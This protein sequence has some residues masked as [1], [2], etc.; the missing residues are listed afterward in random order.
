MR[1]GVGQSTS[2]PRHRWGSRGVAKTPVYDQSGFTLVELLIAFV[3]LPVVMGAISVGLVSVLSLQSSVTGRVTGSA[4]MQTV[5]SV[6]TRDV[7]SA[8]SITASTSSIA[9]D[10][11]TSGERQ[12]LGLQWA[13]GNAAVSYMVVPMNNGPTGPGNNAL[14]T[15]GYSLERVACVFSATPTSTSVVAYDV[16]A[17]QPTALVSC[18]G[19]VPCDASTWLSA[20]DVAVVRLPLYV[21]FGTTPSYWL[22]A[23]P[24]SAALVDLGKTASIVRAPVSLFGLPNQGCNTLTVDNGGSLTINVN[25]GI[26]N[27]ALAVAGTCS[28]SGSSL[29]ST[30][31]NATIN[32][33]S[34]LVESPTTVSG[35][36]APV[37]VMPPSQFLDPFLKLNPPAKPTN[38]GVCTSSVT[39]NGYDYVCLPGYYDTM[40]WA[41]LS[42][43]TNSI[44]FV[45]GAYGFSSF[46][47]PSSN[48]KGQPVVVSFGPGTYWLDGSDAFD[49]SGGHP[50]IIGN[51]ALLYAPTGS[52][53]IGNNS[54]VD[55]TPNADYGGITIWAAGGAPD[56]SYPSPTVTL[57]NNSNYGSNGSCAGADFG[58][59]YVPWGTV[60]T[61]NN[62]TVCTSFIVA[63]A[64]T[65]SQN[66]T[67]SV[68]P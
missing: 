28:T 19:S 8:S 31:Q 26:G 37:Y 12:V 65:L 13:S 42:T 20:T 6:F 52:M 17:S 56:S 32:V 57:G 29:V 25:G 68:A 22:I 54:Y 30:Q 5:L 55:L 9:C 34:V 21:A 49:V 24:R 67:I 33:G 58:G 44:S 11:Q 62:G 63:G 16:N 60:T 3:I 64:A 36:S 27:G 2:S 35:T 43:Q 66:T 14:G 4:S 51:G 50:T 40:P 53:T 18:V 48:S 41:A 59:I 7:Q 38:T 15:T 39:Q 47:L 1:S 61:Q 10:P 45:G 46:L 23:A